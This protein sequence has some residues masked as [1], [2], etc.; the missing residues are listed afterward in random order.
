MLIARGWESAERYFVHARWQLAFELSIQ[1]HSTM[2]AIASRVV[3]VDGYITVPHRIGL[4]AFL[5]IDFTD[6]ED[7]LVLDATGISSMSKLIP[8]FCNGIPA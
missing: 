2:S 7:A 8:T 4:W 3:A 1:Y 5:A 6:S